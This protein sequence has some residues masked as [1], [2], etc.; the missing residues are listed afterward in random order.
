M[1]KSYIKRDSGVCNFVREQK[2]SSVENAA[3]NKNPLSVEVK[4]NE[5]KID[6]TTVRREDDESQKG[7][8]EAERQ[9][10]KKI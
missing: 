7:T 10:T 5:V 8:P 2:F 6:F 9:G 3:D 4:V 1:S